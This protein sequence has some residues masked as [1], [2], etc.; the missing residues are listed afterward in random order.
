MV[1]AVAGSFYRIYERVAS[2][3]RDAGSDGWI[4]DGAVPQLHRRDLDAFR[5]FLQSLVMHAAIGTALGACVRWLVSP[6]TC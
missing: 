6:R 2:G 3:Q 5:A 1:I 4:D